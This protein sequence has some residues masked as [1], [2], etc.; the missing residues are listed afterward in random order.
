MDEFKF[1]MK[2]FLFAAAVVTLSQLKTDGMTIEARVQD[3]LTSN[4]VAHFVNQTAMGGVK[5][6]SNAT[7]TTR[8]KLNDWWSSRSS[9]PQEKVIRY[10][11]AKKSVDNSD[12]RRN[13]EVSP[14]AD[15]EDSYYVE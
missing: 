10:P 13:S 12:L 14:E 9:E 11:A 2:C 6:I 3:T 4:S 5:F 15:F 8:E 1:V 7:E